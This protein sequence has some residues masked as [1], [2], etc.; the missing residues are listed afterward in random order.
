MYHDAGVVTTVS[1]FSDVFHTVVAEMSF[2]SLRILFLSSLQIRNFPLFI[3]DLVGFF[4]FAAMALTVWAEVTA[5]MFQHT[6]HVL[7]P[8]P[9][10]LG[11]FAGA[12]GQRHERT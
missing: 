6:E 5:P 9:P 7:E 11:L 8:E 1:F 3:S 10:P 2:S 4:Y 12:N